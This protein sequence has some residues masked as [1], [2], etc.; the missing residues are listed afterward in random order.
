MMKTYQGSCHCGRV[1]FEAEIDLSAGTGRCN[2]TICTKKRFW[3]AIVKPGAFRLLSGE[4]DL[5]DY[6]FGTQTQRHF[7]CG[8][9]GVHPFGRGRVDVLGG[10]YYSV[11]LACL[12]DVDPA[13]LAS[14]PVRYFDGRHDNWQ[15][16]PAETRHL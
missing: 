16:P 15:T 9:C 10:D 6:Q 13:E 12:D 7:F 5:R 14:A 1:R 2:C 3:G 11:N 4:G 8:A